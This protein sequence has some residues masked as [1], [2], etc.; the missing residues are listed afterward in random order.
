[1]P[2]AC[3]LK[4]ETLEKS[5]LYPSPDPP[6]S[7]PPP[8]PPQGGKGDFEKTPVPPFLRG[9][10]GDRGL[11]VKQQSLTGF[12][13]KLTL[14]GSA[15]SLQHYFGVGKR[16]CRVLRCPNQSII[17]HEP[18]NIDHYHCIRRCNLRN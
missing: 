14:M 10:R 3:Q 11:I 13:L 2:K 6:K 7:P 4:P 16:H 9:A 1:M 12:D 5:R 18:L 17:R 15:V 8:S